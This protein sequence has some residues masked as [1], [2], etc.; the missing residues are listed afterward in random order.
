MQQ[1][2][3]HLPDELWELMK[4]WVALE[5]NFLLPGIRYWVEWTKEDMDNENSSPIQGI[6]TVNNKL[7][8][9]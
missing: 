7:L 1:I 9:D 2:T 5:G 8:E 6:A 3:L 4:R